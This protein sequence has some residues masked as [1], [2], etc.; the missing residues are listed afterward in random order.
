MSCLPSDG[1]M[2]W[3]HGKEQEDA[4]CTLSHQV[5]PPLKPCLIIFHV[6]ICTHT[7]SQIRPF[8]SHL[9]KKNPKSQNLFLAL[10]EVEKS[11]VKVQVGLVSAEKHLSLQRQ[12]AMVSL[13]SSYKNTNLMMGPHPR[14][15]DLVTFQSPILKYQQIRN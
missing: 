14:E 10:L 9:K 11:R 4:G 15:P 7:Q 8:C 13:F 1:V 12:S 6:R 2:R 5:Q 3:R